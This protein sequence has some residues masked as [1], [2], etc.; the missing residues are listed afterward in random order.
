MTDGDDDACESG[1]ED[2]DD[3]EDNQDKGSDRC[4][5]KGYV[6]LPGHK[7]ARDHLG[8]LLQWL[9]CMQKVR[10]ILS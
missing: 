3:D 6:P 8:T 10:Y 9:V 1:E 2:S 4:E 5:D 7:L